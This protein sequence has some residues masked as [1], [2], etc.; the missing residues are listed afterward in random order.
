M[1]GKIIDKNLTEAFIALE[2][3]DTIDISISRLPKDVKL[4]D[5]IDIPKNNSS[6]NNNDRLVD[7]F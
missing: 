6:I 1:K 2:N 5:K 4:G 7:F 3:G